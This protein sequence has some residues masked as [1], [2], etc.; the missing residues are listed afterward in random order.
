MASPQPEEHLAAYAGVQRAADREILAALRLAYRDVGR[1]LGKLGQQR[2]PAS[3]ERQRLL[4]VKKAI[5]E[6]Q[7]EFYDK[8]GDIIAKRR[9]EAA[10]RAIKVS[11][12]YDEAVFA[13]AGREDDLRALSESLEETE[14]RAP[15]RMI[16][17][18]TGSR[19]P[20]SERVYRTRAYTQGLLERRINSGLARGLSAQEL[21]REVRDLVNPN[22]PG[23]VRFAALRLARTEI[24]N[25]YHAMAI[26]AAELKPWVTY[27]EWHTS[28]SHV[29]LDKC[30]QLNKQTF[31]PADTPRKPHPQC[32][33]YV[34]EITGD[35][36][37]SDEENDDAFL[38]DLVS[39]LF[40]NFLDSYG[41]NQQGQS[42]ARDRATPTNVWRS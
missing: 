4:A 42:I 41:A 17:R 37:K 31:T 3:L 22:T 7:A 16:A 12:R 29:R 30:D 27:L 25:A 40:D 20:L 23:G 32:M 2:G 34:T 9:V 5:L 10:A 38:D 26:R 33:C 15:E 1:E 39:G 28:D 14:A 8:A 13:R 18:M 6:A 36:D 11:A 35:P 19:L 21:A 24:N